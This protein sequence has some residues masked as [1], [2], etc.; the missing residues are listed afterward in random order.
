MIGKWL[1]NWLSGCHADGSLT[2]KTTEEI[3]HKERYD[4]MTYGW[5]KSGDKKG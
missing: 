1:A 2:R 5:R 3:K 4:D